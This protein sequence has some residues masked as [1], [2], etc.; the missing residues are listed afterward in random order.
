MNERRQIKFPVLLPIGKDRPEQPAGAGASQEVLLIR[1]LFIGIAWRE[2]HA[3]NSQ[4]HHLVKK[5]AYALGIRTV[6]QCRIGRDPEAA[7]HSF[8]DAIHG[9][10]VSTFAANREVVVFL[11]AIEMDAEGEVLAWLEEMN[12]LFEQQSV[13][14]QVNVLLARHQPFHDLVDFGMHE[15]F[16]AR[17][18]NHGRAALIHRP[19][20]LLGREL[21]L[22]HVGGVLDLAAACASQ[23]AAEQ[24]LQHQHQRI[25]LPPGELLPYDIAG[26]RPHLRYRNTHA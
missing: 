4:V 3:L 13:G 7:L 1:R 17:N 22:E 16:A 15:R 23:V 25:L 6:K 18:G 10:F 2:H 12:L 20:A 9:D 11:L 26:H 8:T 19:E 5:R 24:R 21:A 14:A